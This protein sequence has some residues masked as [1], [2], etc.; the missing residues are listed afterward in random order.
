MA[1]TFIRQDAQ[2]A[3]TLT[4]IVGFVDNTAPAATMQSAATTIADDLNNI[5]SMVSYL[6]DLQG[7]NW[8]DPLTAPASFGDAGAIRGVQANSDD[9]YAVERQRILK[10]EH[11]IGL[12]ITGGALQAVTLTLAQVPATNTA[13]IGAA[14]TLG[15]VVATATAFGTASATDVVAG[16]NALQ[17]KNLVRMMDG[18]T[19]DP[20][21]DGSGREIM[22]L[23]QSESAINGSTM[24]GTTPNRVQISYV[25]RNATNDGLQLI[26]A[27]EMS[28]ISF[29]YA[30]IKRDAFQDCPEESWLGDDFADAGSSN[31]TRQTVY[32]TQGATPVDLGTNATLDL[33]GAGLYWE[34]RDDLEA[35]LF[36]VIDGS[37]GGTS[38]VQIAAGVDVFNVDALVNDFASG[39]TINSGGTRPITVGV[40]D[41]QIDTTAGDLMVKAFAE[42]LLDDGNQAASTWAQDG[43]KLS[44]TSAEWDLFETNFGEVSLLNGINQ[45]FSGG[46]RTKIQA[47]MTANAAADTN[48]NGPTYAAN[49]DVDLAPYN[50]VTFVDDV[51]IFLNGELLRN[52]AVLGA[53]DVY[54]GSIPA[55]GDLKF[56]FALQGTGAKPDQ[57]TM[58]V[59]GQ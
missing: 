53:E 25:V 49:C 22:G 30:S 55:Q 14:V 45:A 44:D 40:T 56:T 33:E 38:E 43:I 15:T 9:L 52:N 8:Y 32:D 57:F 4:S 59:N 20:I 3:S 7:G 26:A 47:T 6:N 2:I 35:R 11:Q 23:L 13:A 29:D 50:L 21:V 19:G 37:A 41:G 51:E 34:I 18:T 36:A 27:T 31:A 39:A 10:R 17:P 46:V 54:P 5:R 12:D 58:I 1:R 16:A 24:T 28:G 48:V 42:L